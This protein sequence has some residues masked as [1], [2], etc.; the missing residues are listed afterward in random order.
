[1]DKHIMREFLNLPHDGKTCL[2]LNPQNLNPLLKC[3]EVMG[4]GCIVEMK[5]PDEPYTYFEKELP[6]KNMGDCGIKYLIY[7]KKKL[8]KD[9]N[10]AYRFIPGI[11][12]IENPTWNKSGIL[13][14]DQEI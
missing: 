10:S 6:I 11:N 3:L 4:E 12:M 14:C 2:V 7:R 1:M 8:S 9:N 13:K 5:L